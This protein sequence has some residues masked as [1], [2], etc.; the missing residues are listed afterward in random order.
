ML[1]PYLT[2]QGGNNAQFL[3]RKAAA[4]AQSATDWLATYAD[5]KGKAIACLQEGNVEAARCWET[6]PI[7]NRCID[8]GAE[9]QRPRL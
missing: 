3:F 1:S 9:P 6:Q 2:H 8:E 7:F 4:S 5:C